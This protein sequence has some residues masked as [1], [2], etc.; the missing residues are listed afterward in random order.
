MLVLVLGL[1]VLLIVEPGFIASAWRWMAERSRQGDEGPAAVEAPPLEPIEEE[2]PGT[3]FAPADAPVEEEPAP[4]RTL[5]IPAADL[6][7]IS[8][9][10]P[11]L[12]AEADAWFGM[13]KVLRATDE[14]AL[15]DAATGRVIYVQLFDQP[16]VYRGKLV[17]VR[18]RIRRTEL[19][20]P[21]ENP[22]GFTEYYRLVLQPEDN[23]RDPVIVYSL[24]LPEGFPT[25]MSV[26][27]EVLVTGYFFKRWE[28][29]GQEDLLIAPAMLSKTVHWIPAPEVEDR[30]ARGPGFWARIALGVA[31]AVLVSLYVYY[32]T[33]RG[34]ALAEAESP[35]AR[36]FRREEPPRDV[37]KDLADLEDVDRSG[38]G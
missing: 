27:E 6:A 38:G 34:G 35:A 18:G 26:D 30:S 33:R 2:I 17:S 21:H 31:F 8:D 23:P 29:E 14:K 1:A 9:D 10:A 25:G 4:A 22:H 24:G 11:F 3:F 19:V 36:M 5:E 13:L 37:H 20:Y 12:P 32:R 15:E 7:E 28:Y 16:E